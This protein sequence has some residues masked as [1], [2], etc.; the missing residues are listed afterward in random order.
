VVN[1]GKIDDDEWTYVNG[2]LV[3]ATRGCQK[4]RHYEIKPGDPAYAALSFGG[5]NVIA[6]QVLDGGGTGGMW[7]GVPAIGPTSGALAWTPVSPV[8]EV[9]IDQSVRHAV[10]SWGPGGAFFNSWETSRGA[11]GFKVDGR[12]VVFAGPLSALGALD[13]DVHEA[14]TDFAVSRPWIFQPLAYTETNRKL[15]VPDRG[16]R[17]PCAARVVN[18]ATGGEIVLIPASVARTP[19]GPAVLKSLQ[20][21]SDRPR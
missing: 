10:V 6:I 2:A 11:F 20:I 13:V 17:Y 21:N 16:E 1:L 19:A 3:G 18:R 5:D 7:A 12:G 15:L 14:F 4:V 9:V 8:E